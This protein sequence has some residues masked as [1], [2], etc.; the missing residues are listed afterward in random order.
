MSIILAFLASVA[1]MA[2]WWLVR[3]GVT[4][5]PWLE[6]GPPSAQAAPF[7]ST[8]RVG[9]GIF[10]AVVGCLF[11]LL[12]SA[13]V[14]RMDVEAWPSPS[15]PPIIWANTVQL[16]LAS[17]FLHMAAASAQRG[18]RV[19]LRRDTTLATLATV[20]FLAGQV[21]AWRELDLQGGI[22]PST[23]AGFFYLLSGLHA[24]HILGGLGALGLVTWRHETDGR[25]LWLCVAYWDFLLVVW[26]GLLVLL[27]GWTNRFMELCRSVLT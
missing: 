14:M 21:L 24:L 13:F 26:L 22:T 1:A 4:S 7:R 23:A 27:M 18:D 17:L 25:R 6:A 10:L 3:Q 11:A 20:G 12:G 5:K 19:G 2:L 15:L 16:V 9:L 8:E